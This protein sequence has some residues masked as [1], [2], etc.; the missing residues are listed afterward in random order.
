MSMKSTIRK[1]VSISLLFG[2]FFIAKAQEGDSTVILPH[3]VALWLLERH[4]LAE[5]LEVRMNIKDSTITVLKI[6]IENRDLII[7]EFKAS[8]IEYEEIIESV[9]VE[10]DTWKKDSD[11]KDKVVKKLKFHRVLL[12]IGILL[13]TVLSFL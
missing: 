13:V 7:V 5:S 9:K 2:F 10:R 11:I 6:R 8:K 4:K 12:S 1:I 3:P